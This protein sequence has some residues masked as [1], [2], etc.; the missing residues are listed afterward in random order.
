MVLHRAAL[1]I[2]LIHL[3]PTK[4]TISNH[5]KPK[6]STRSTTTCTWL[7]SRTTWTKQQMQLK[8]KSKLACN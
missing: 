7:T 4:L 2:D 8:R 6:R 1:L 3:T 5:S